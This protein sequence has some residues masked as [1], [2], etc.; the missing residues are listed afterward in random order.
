MASSVVQSLRAIRSVWK[1]KME[2][3]AVQTQLCGT[4]FVRVRNHWNDFPRGA[5]NTWKA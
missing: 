2:P 5:V 4:C 1:L 3:K